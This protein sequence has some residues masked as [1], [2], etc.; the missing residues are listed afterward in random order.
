MKRFAFM[1]LAL[2]LVGCAQAEVVNLRLGPEGEILAWL[3]AGP[4]PNPHNKDFKACRGF[5][6]DYLRKEVK[7]RPIE[8]RKELFSLSW[9]LAVGTKENGI[10]LLSVFPNSK[11]AVGYLYAGIVSKSNITAHLLVGSDDGVKVWV[12]GELLHVSHQTRGV[13]RDEE[14]LEVRL[15]EGV[16]HILFKVDQHFGGWGLIARIVGTNG[17]PIAHLREVLDI[18]SKP[19]KKESLALVLLRTAVGKQGSLDV[20]VLNQ[21]IKWEAKSTFWTPWL[22][23]IK[24]NAI[25]LQTSLTTWRKRL[26]VPPPNADVLSAMLGEAAFDLERRFNAAWDNFHCYMQAPR[27][28]L[29]VDPTKEDYIR[30][31]PGGRYFVH[32]DGRFFTP[33]GYNHNP[34]WTPL[35]R[36]APGRPGYDLAVAEEFFKRLKDSGVNLLRM[37]IDLPLSSL[38]EKPIGVFVPEHVLWIDEIVKL[39]RKH[40]IKLMITPWDTFWMNHRWDE[41]PY[42][43]KNGG[44]VEKKVD[45]ITKREVIEAQKRRWKYII[46]RWGN[47]GAI[48]AWELLNEADYWW[49]ASPEQVIAWAKEIGDFVRNYE[50]SKWGRN[51]L[52]CISTGRPMP[53]EGWDDLAY[54]LPGMDFATT[55][56]YIGVSNAPDEP[57]GPAFTE[58]QGVEYA[59][60]QIKDNRPYID[61]E[62]GPINRWIA[63]VNLDNEVFHN[64]SWAHLA[65]G[66]AGSG[67]RWPYRNP[68]HLSDGM[69]RTLALMSHFAKEVPWRKLV[70]NRVTVEVPVPEGWVSCS[71]STKECA[72]VW[73]AAPKAER[74]NICLSWPNGPKSARYRCYDTKT[75]EWVNGAATLVD[76]KF[77]IRL[78]GEHV[79]VAVILE[80]F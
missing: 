53:K 8:G 1:L 80:N 2:L 38:I 25:P 75:G 49:G 15:N 5:E 47:T 10:D 52:I 35:N 6:T 48:F 31:A 58:K 78:P 54:H 62:N 46:D 68:H 69:Y 17:L 33:I 37:M 79:S 64:M 16:N 30:V 13:K 14:R 27:A 22:S 66:G 11:A 65:S 18:N 55:H 36:C 32:S 72:L 29:D 40:D 28:L 63:D 70:G 45:F 61:G 24:D 76:G 74:M 50:K 41:N 71:I 39:A 43:V 77:D 26:S 21:Y 9:R 12:N 20:D 4:F 44:P 34:E 23:E 60:S 3:V 7:A 51:H 57:I 56:L 19:A 73:V 42:N 67:L 59:I